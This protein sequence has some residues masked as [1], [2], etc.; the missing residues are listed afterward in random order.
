MDL[1]DL[2]IFDHFCHLT[3]EETGMNFDRVLVIVA[4]YVHTVSLNIIPMTI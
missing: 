3:G 1:Y 4:R 2:V